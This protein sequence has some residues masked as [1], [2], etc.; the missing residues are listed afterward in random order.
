MALC[1]VLTQRSLWQSYHKWIVF[2][3]RSRLHDLATAYN[4]IEDDY[5]VTRTELGSI[6]H[7]NNALYE[8]NVELRQAS[9]DG[10]A[11]ADAIEEL[12]REREKLSVDLADRAATIK[13]LL[14]ENS[15]LTYKLSAAQR[16]AESLAI[17]TRT[18]PERENPY[19]F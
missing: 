15:E 17:L 8:E 5:Y 18:P 14:E 16:E 12:S 13:S 9:M 4:K 1:K 3:Y 10:I 7:D 11:I 19:R 2:L 6:G